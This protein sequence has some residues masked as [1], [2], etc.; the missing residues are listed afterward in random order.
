MA[1]IHTL[2]LAVH[3]QKEHIQGS[4]TVQFGDFSQR[5]AVDGGVSLWCR[6][7]SRSCTYHQRACLHERDLGPI[8]LWPYDCLP[9][10]LTIAKILMPLCLQGQHS[11]TLSIFS[12]TAVY[13]PRLKTKNKQQNLTKQQVAAYNRFMIQHSML[14]PVGPF[15]LLDIHRLTQG[16][17]L[18]PQAA[19][20]KPL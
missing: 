5:I 11:P 13:P 3:M 14:A 2:Q 16:G 15:Q 1:R 7:C 8:L 6:C 4:N 20:G 9:A 10:S 19:S 17:L 12:I 18:H